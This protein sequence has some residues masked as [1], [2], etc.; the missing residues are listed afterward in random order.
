MGDLSGFQRCVFPYP[1][2]PEVQKI[3]QIFPEQ[4]NLSVHSSPFWFGH[5]SPRVPKSGQ[6]SEADG[7]SK[8]YSD[9]AV[10]RRL[11][12]ES[13]VPGNLPTTYP[14]RLGPVPAVRVGSQ[15]RRLPVQPV[16]RS[17][18]THSGPVDSSSREVILHQELEHLD[19]QT[20]DVFN[21]TAYSH[22][23]TSL[24]RTS[25]YEAHSV[26]LEASLARPQGFRK[27]HTSSSITPSRPRLV[28]GREQC[29]KV[30]T[31]APSS[32]HSLA[33]Y[34]R[35]KRRL[36]RTLRGL[37]CKRRLVSHRKSS[38]H[39]LFRAKGSPLA[40]KSFEHL[41]RDQIVLVATDNTTVVSYINKQ[42]GM[43]S[44]LSVPSYGG[45]C[46]GAIP[47]E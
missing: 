17:G 25:S 20:V 23:K 18:S 12:T 26:A 14:D 1:N 31:F 40:L 13:P 19:S 3:P 39:Q 45:F 9:P 30:P 5:G 42:V 6:R 10:P 36:G 38:P 4:S 28:V 2:L 7:T 35:L 34:R 24:V 15:F 11:V 37:H 41:C 33:V 32:A 22:R 21:R 47:G 29:T 46:P 44:A 27:D 8:G 43:K 16:I